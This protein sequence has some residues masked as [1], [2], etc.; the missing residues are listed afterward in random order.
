MEDNGRYYNLY[1]LPKYKK[2]KLKSLDL[3]ESGLKKLPDMSNVSVSG[4]L[5]LSTTK[6]KNLKGCPKAVQLRLFDCNNLEKDCLK[7]LPE[8]VE[9][10]EDFNLGIEALQYLPE[11]T[12]LR[13]VEFQEDDLAHDYACFSKLPLRLLAGMEFENV[14]RSLKKSIKKP[15]VPMRKSGGWRPT[16]AS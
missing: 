5:D 16:S 8:D 7:D 11:K 15:C 12:S 2:F 13:R 1:D 6:I 4:T 10:L 3:S 9:V 14:P